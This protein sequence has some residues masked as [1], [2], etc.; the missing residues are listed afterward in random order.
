MDGNGNGGTIMDTGTTFSLLHPVAFAALKAS[1]LANRPSPVDSYL[2]YS[3]CW[4]ANTPGVLPS[5]VLNFV[6]GDMILNDITAYHVGSGYTCLAM[7]PAPD[8]TGVN[9][10]GNWQITDRFMVFDVQNSQ[11]SHGGYD[12]SRLAI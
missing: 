6:G 7:L 8:D 4:P 12:C 3:P 9:L 1:L 2:G 10:I 11:I 5:I